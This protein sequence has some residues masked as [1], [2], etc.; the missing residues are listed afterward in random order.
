[1]DVV[2]A[3]NKAARTGTL[4]DLEKASRQLGARLVTADLAMGDGSPRHDPVLLARA[5]NQMFAVSS[6][7][8][9]SAV[10]Q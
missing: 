3:D 10:W 5:F 7:M 6:Q 8:G 9:G 1:V 4:T 2:L